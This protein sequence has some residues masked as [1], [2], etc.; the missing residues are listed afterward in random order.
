[1]PLLPE[2]E[3]AGHGQI[4][5]GDFSRALRDQQ[6]AVPDGIV[7]PDGEVSNKRFS[8]YRNN[9][10]LSLS[11]ALAANFPVIKRL[12]G[13][14]FFAALAK[15]FI[16]QH[17]AKVP[18]L[19]AYGDEFAV[20]LERFEPVAEFPYLADVA[21]VEFAWL[22]AYH[23]ADLDIL[24]GQQL[25][26][27]AAE[28]VGNV[29]FTAHPASWVF[30]SVWPVGTIVA[31]NQEEGDC[32]DID[33]SQGEDILITRPL[34]DVETRIL[35]SGGY[36]FLSALVAGNTLEQAAGAA[37]SLDAEFDLS[38]QITGML[39]CGVFS[40]INIDNNLIEPGISE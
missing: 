27:V 18:M 32:S 39:E 30:R 33:L 1:M 14:E 31:R 26:A 9:V 28:E 35:P 37:A 17:S 12:V 40:A 4:G 10:A 24:D 29:R 21:R 11:D 6:L 19:F 13:D 25:G 16:A 22:Q 20:F 8:I 36:E 23:A 15:A 2:K 38:M 7:G 3:N 34:L 5:L